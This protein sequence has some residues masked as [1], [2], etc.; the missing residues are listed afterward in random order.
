[1][2]R[3]AIIGSS[4]LGQLIAHHI[5]S[6]KQ[7]EVVGFLDDWK[8]KGAETEQGRILGG[9]NDAISYYMEGLFECILIAIGYKHLAFR[10]QYY[11]KIVEE[12]P[13]ISYVH[14]SCV[15]DSTVVLGKGAV[16]LPGCTIDKGVIVGENTIINTGCVIA[17]DTQIGPHSFLGPGVVAAGFVNVGQECFLGVHTTIIDNIS[18]ASGVQTGGGTVVIKNLLSRGVYVGCPAK[19]M[20]K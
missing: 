14:S 1:M 12:I 20:T 13:V 5:S 3:L 10:K 9:L 6:D 4:D 7:Y 15:I 17:H 8:E 11:I 2:K 19:R 16:V 18:I